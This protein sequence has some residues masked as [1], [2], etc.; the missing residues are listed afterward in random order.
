MPLTPRQ[1]PPPTKKSL[2]AE[3]Y[4]DAYLFSNK[5]FFKI[6]YVTS[7]FLRQKAV[8]HFKKVLCCEGD[9]NLA[10]AV[11]PV[12][13]R[14]SEAEW[15]RAGTQKCFSCHLCDV[16]TSIRDVGVPCQYREGNSTRLTALSWEFYQQSNV[17]C[18][19]RPGFPC[20]VRQPWELGLEAVG[21]DLA[22]L[23]KPGQRCSC[24][25]SHPQP[26]Q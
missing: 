4:N 11:R 7:G 22:S 8:A 13:L 21:R 10:H 6:R 26:H 1:E 23:A 5:L 14:G 12:Y 2:L 25:E 9:T 18:P 24:R 16:S 19:G 3:A 15:F 17:S 20:G